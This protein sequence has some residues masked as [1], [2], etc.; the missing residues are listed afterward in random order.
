[1]RRLPRGFAAESLALLAA[2]IGTLL[3]TRALA[4]EAFEV[5]VL[6][7]GNIRPGARGIRGHGRR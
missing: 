2:L 4:G 7:G 3:A 6:R 1:M 5:T